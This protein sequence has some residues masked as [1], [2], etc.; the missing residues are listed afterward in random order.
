MSD[1][2]YRASPKK[3]WK[4]WVASGFVLIIVFGVWRFFT[5]PEPRYVLPRYAADWAAWGTC[6]GAVGTILVVMYAAGQLQQSVRTSAQEAENQRRQLGLL[7]EEALQRRRELDHLNGEVVRQASKL[8]IYAAFKHTAYDEYGASP[9]LNEVTFYFDNVG[10]QQFR[11]LQ[12]AITPGDNVDH[13]EFSRVPILEVHAAKRPT[14][15]AGA[16]QDFEAVELPGPRYLLG[17]VDPM[18]TVMLTFVFA[19]NEN[20]FEWEATWNVAARMHEAPGIPMQV[21]YG[22]SDGRT[23]LRSSINPS[24]IQRVYSFKGG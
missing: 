7:E 4:A 12:V 15:D 5:L 23:W 16:Q 11:E 20:A 14:R 1:G 18:E 8:G 13:V 24:K 10:N 9:Y 17:N 21:T 2:E 22:D 3:R 19:T 6:I